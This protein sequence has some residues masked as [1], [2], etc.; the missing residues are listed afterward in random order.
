MGTQIFARVAQ[1]TIQAVA[2]V[3]IV[4]CPAQ[5]VTEES[6][7][8]SEP[9]AIRGEDWVRFDTDECGTL[10]GV[11]DSRSL[12]TKAG[13]VEQR[14][15]GE[16]ERPERLDAWGVRDGGLSDAEAWVWMHPFLAIQTLA[17]QRWCNGRFLIRDDDEFEALPAALRPTMYVPATAA[18]A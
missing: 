9:A 3:A 15:I 18:I 11:A 7:I 1:R 17:V 2:A 5:A 12:A 4:C 10:N 6:L 16:P 13:F 8:Y 14:P